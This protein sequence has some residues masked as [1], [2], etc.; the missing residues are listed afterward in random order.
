MPRH[1]HE[2]SPTVAFVART[3]AASAIRA[4]PSRTEAVPPSRSSSVSEYS[5]KRSTYSVIRCSHDRVITHI[6]WSRPEYVNCR[7]ESAAGRADPRSTRVRGGCS[8]SVARG[9]H[10]RL[11]R[12]AGAAPLLPTPSIRVVRRRPHRVGYVVY[13][14]RKLPPFRAR[15]RST[16]YFEGPHSVP[17]DRGARRPRGR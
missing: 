1:S 3:R 11:S 7:T 16:W 6:A 5:V 8:N 4:P 15:G 13:Q 12:C 17:V 2:C 10:R 14:Q 9:L